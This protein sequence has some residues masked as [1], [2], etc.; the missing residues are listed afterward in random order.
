MKLISGLEIGAAAKV[1]QS[2]ADSYV[3]YQEKVVAE[4]GA[5]RME[6]RGGSEQEIY[7]QGK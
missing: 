7:G 6:D 2:S 1:V 5:A 4:V 3:A